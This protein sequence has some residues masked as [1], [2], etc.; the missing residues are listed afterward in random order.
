MGLIRVL[1]DAVINQIA[2]GEVI[3]NPASVVKELVE[4]SLDAGAKR[5]WVEIRGGGFQL[6]QVADNGSGMSRDDAVLAF[7]RH[8]TSKIA[9]IDDLN[10][11]HTMGFR[12]EALASIASVARVELVTAEEGKDGTEVVVEGGVMK[13]ARP[14][15]RDRGTTIQVRSLFYNVPARKKFQ[16]SS[17]ATTS[18]IHRLLLTLA[19]A[20]PD[21]SFEFKSHDELILSAEGEVENSLLS[22][23]DGRIGSVFES[24]FM[25]GRRALEAE[26][27]GYWVQ[28]WIG[29]PV[30]DRVNRSSQYLFI[31]QRSVISPLVAAS[32][33]AG[34]GHRLGEKRYPI[35]VVQLGVPPEDVDVNVH[36]QKREVRFRDEERL[37]E[38]LRRATE[39]AFHET[40]P[41]VVSFQERS[42]TVYSAMPLAFR[43]E[44]ASPELVEIPD[45]IGMY[46]H[47][48]LLHAHEEGILWVDLQK[49]EEQMV[50]SSLTQESSGV[51]SQ[52]LLI[53]IPV[54]LSGNLDEK[55]QL[56]QQVGYSV[57][58]SG[59][60]Q[61]LIDGIPP[62]LEMS[63]ATEGL[64]L[65]L[66]EEDPFKR[67]AT[68]AVRGKKRF[69]LQEALALWNKVKHSPGPA[70]IAKTGPHEIKKL[71][72]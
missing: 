47:Y 16:K 28:G 2:A 51:R 41:T 4:N 68:F 67:L 66:E 71:F 15:S 5:I 72:R 54:E 69:M 3:E 35:F 8:A 32:I 60:N 6:I 70:V 18:E 53:P 9:K 46:E 12:G 24:S 1:N 62:F 38:F 25:L 13:S 58:R 7:E 29:S 11:L 42:E 26:H 19:L 33:R 64:K 21:V 34:Y 10:T 63:D 17:S 45:V 36:P 30:D 48:L 59:K 37:R 57:Q 56:L 52:G 43:E 39:S 49:A 44:N 27:E 50:L 40:R 65:V 61:Y 31:N 14:A 22:N 23:L 20:R 55:Q